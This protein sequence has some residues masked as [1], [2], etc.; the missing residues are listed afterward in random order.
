LSKNSKAHFRKNVRR[1]ID[2]YEVDIV[3][4][5]T[6]DEISH[7]YTLY[8]NVKSHSLDLNTFSLPKKLFR[9]IILSRDWETLVLRVTPEEGPKS[10]VAVVFSHIAS[11]NYIPMIIGL[12]YDF[13]ANYKV[14]RQALY[15][16]VMRAGKLGKKKVLLGFSAAIEKKKVGATTT[17]TYA[18]MQIKDNYNAQTLS[19]MNLATA[20]S[21]K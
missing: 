19:M 3:K 15:Q 13:N 6:N 8:E 17:P 5:P 16:V 18:F 10:T 14:Y 20:T 9:N 12:D 2:K 21:N 4:Q 11:D 1:Y 7:W